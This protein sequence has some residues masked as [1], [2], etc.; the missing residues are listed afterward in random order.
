[1][2]SL[3]SYEAAK[4]ETSVLIVNMGDPTR[5]TN[6]IYSI[7]GKEKDYIFPFETV[8]S[9][10]IKRAI[11]ITDDIANI[12]KFITIKKN[13]ENV[14]DS[15]LE[16]ELGSVDARYEYIIYNR[17]YYLGFDIK[18]LDEMLNKLYSNNK[19]SNITYDI[20]FSPRDLTM[21][22]YLNIY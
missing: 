9:N 14:I 1:M 22:T 16:K 7:N 17:E 18:Y 3:N 19:K 4:D 10:K 20:T 2:K 5:Y 15:D 12:K 11:F 21:S 13:K 8:I 6:K